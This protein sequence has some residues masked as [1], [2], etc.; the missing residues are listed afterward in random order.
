MNSV[1][2]ALLIIALSAL[3]LSV[4]AS[5]GTSAEDTSWTDVDSESGLTEALNGGAKNIRIVSDITVTGNLNI[6][7]GV[8]VL[9]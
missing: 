7:A 1:A 5:P 3:A 6:P 9:I 4:L 2:K 8:K